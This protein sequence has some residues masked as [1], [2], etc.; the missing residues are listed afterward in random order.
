[1][2]NSNDIELCIDMLFAVNREGTM[3]GEAGVGEQEADILRSILFERIDP[4]GSFPKYRHVQDAADV[5]AFSLVVGCCFDGDVV[6]RLLRGFKRG[7][8][9][10]GVAHAQLS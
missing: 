10:N 4:E 2:D 8:S 6:F 9:A 1:M 7:Q 5:V 3:N